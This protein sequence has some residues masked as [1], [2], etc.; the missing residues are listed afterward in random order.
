MPA[1]FVQL[2]IRRVSVDTFE[3]ICTLC[4]LITLYSLC[5]S[6]GPYKYHLV[7]VSGD[8]NWLKRLFYYLHDGF[9]NCRLEIGNNML[10]F[11]CINSPSICKSLMSTFLHNE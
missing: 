5:V 9:H 11:T 10:A 7:S 1:C 6:R 2:S 3:R 8:K 4:D